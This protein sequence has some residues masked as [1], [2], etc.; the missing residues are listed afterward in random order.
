MMDR[1]TRQPN[2]PFRRLVRAAWLIMLLGHMPAMIQ[3]WSTWLSSASSAG[4][5]FRC[6]TLTP[7]V[8]LFILKVI[9]VPWLRVARDGR[10]LLTMTIAVALLHA[11]VIQRMSTHLPDLETSA[12]E[13]TLAGGLLAVLAGA[14]R[15]MRRFEFGDCRRL[16]RRTHANLVCILNR[17]I[18]ALLRP[19]F[20]LLA[21]ACGVNRAPPAQFS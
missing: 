5:L 1:L 7:A 8:L 14:V 21:R 15:R 20:E 9:D 2:R 17:E 12:I 11:G 4:D 3:A 18:F 10:G 6:L 19:R 16:R 13:A